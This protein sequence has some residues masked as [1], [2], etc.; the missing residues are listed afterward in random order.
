MAFGTGTMGLAGG[1]V[2]DIFK[3]QA[4]AKSLRLKAEGDLVEA[5]NYDLAAD[6]AKQSAEFTRQSTAIKETQAQRQL[7]L[8]LGKTGSD[9]ASA[10][11]SMSGSALDLMRD[12]AAQGG[13]TKAV[14]GQQGL[15]T[16]AG[17]NEQAQAYTNLAGYAR[18]AANEE[19][20]MADTA[21]TN[22]YI[23]GGIKGAAA[24]AT[25]FI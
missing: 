9:V 19:R 25:L 10:G 5:Q 2:D 15:I 18:Y 7:Y 1:A 21:E 17:F 23:T 22:G 11:F 4:T 12:S 14:I 24:I 3:G 20:D 16:E 13:L 6:L 8:G